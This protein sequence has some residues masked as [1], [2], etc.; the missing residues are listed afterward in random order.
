VEL[1]PEAGDE[2]AI[3]K[4]LKAGEKV[5]TAANFLVDAESRL[6]GAFANM[7]KPSVPAA[8]ATSAA[9]TQNLNVE[10][11]EPKSANVGGNPVRVAVHDASG[12]PVDDVQVEIR[13]FMPQMGN[14]AP[15][16]SKASLQ[17]SGGGQYTGTVDVPM[18]WT[19]Q[20]TITV[21]RGDQVIGTKQ[22]NLTAR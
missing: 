22:L 1:G 10:V 16:N 4:G 8:G 21:K 17:S 2:Y 6:K 20:T 19:W 5:V 3:Q 18:A 14:M 9:T 12:Q 11:L 15:M 7:G 13:L